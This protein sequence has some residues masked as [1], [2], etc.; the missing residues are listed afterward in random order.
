MGTP[1]PPSPPEERHPERPTTS[2]GATSLE[3]LTTALDRLVLSRT[4]TTE[5]ARA[6]LR[7]LALPIPPERPPTLTGVP[8][9]PGV[10]APHPPTPHPSGP[11]PA[12]GHD[13]AA[14][15]GAD[16]GDQP[17]AWAAVLGEVGGYV[18]AALVLGGCVVLAGPG[19]D[20]LS[21]IDRVVL[22]AGPALVL[23][24]TAGVSAAM[25]P[26]G[27]TVRPRDGA[28]ARRRWVASLV[29]LAAVLLGAAVGQLLGAA[30]RAPGVAATTASVCAAGY[31]LCRSPLLQ[32]GWAVAVAAALGELLAR[33]PLPAPTAWG[34][35]LA[36]A[37]WVGLVMARVIDEWTVGVLL[38]GALGYVGGQMLA[39]GEDQPLGYLV[40]GAL[41]VGGLAGYLWTRR[42]AVLVVGVVSLATVVPEAV[43]HYAGGALRT[44]GALLVAGLSIVGASALGLALRR[45]PPSHRAAPGR[46]AGEPR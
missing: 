4:L 32:A 20:T 16:G 17:Q 1:H 12:D 5:Q 9:T 3:A 27:W 30:N 41:A 7:E 6:V 33:S 43:S 14:G 18:G 25:T 22:L 10:I 29:T 8:L 13:P 23:L 19:W 42:V 31:A 35:V 45:R 11:Q 37:L 46:T 26:G 28:S 40:M 44:G 24:L 36:G 39:L 34:F 15:T 2:D 21:R 38:A